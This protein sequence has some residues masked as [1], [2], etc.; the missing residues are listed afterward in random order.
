MSN[1]EALQSLDYPLIVETF[2]IRF[3]LKIINEAVLH[4]FN[5]T[6]VAEEYAKKFQCCGRT[7]RN[8]Y[9][10]KNKGTLAFIFKDKIRALA[11]IKKDFKPGLQLFIDPRLNFPDTVGNPKLI[12]DETAYLFLEEAYNLTKP[13]KERHSL[14]KEN[15]ELK[16]KLNQLKELAKREGGIE[17]R[18]ALKIMGLELNVP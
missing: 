12:D 13:P 7:I 18:E 1:N 10:K 17:L 14:R 9:S 2:R 11:V 4:N 5:E 3:H 15:V 16:N 6:Y 8:V